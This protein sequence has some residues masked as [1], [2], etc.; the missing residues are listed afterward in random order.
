MSNLVNKRLKRYHDHNKMGTSFAQLSQDAVNNLNAKYE[1]AIAE[2]LASES[3]LGDHYRSLERVKEEDESFPEDQ[4]SD[5]SSDLGELR[6]GD[7]VKEESKEFPQDKSDTSSIEASRSKITKKRK[8]SQS[9]EDASD[10]AGPI[11]MMNRSAGLLSE[12]SR[13]LNSTYS[14]KHLK[15]SSAKSKVQASVFPEDESDVISENSKES[16]DLKKESSSGSDIKNVNLDR[17]EQDLPAR[18]SQHSDYEDKS[19]YSRVNS[20][21]IGLQDPMTSENLEIRRGHPKNY[22]EKPDDFEPDGEKVI[23]ESEISKVKSSDSSAQD[24]NKQQE[25]EKY[26]NMEYQDN[27][28]S[29]NLHDYNQDEEIIGQSDNQN[30]EVKGQGSY[31]DGQSDD[32]Q[33]PFDIKSA[34]RASNQEI[35]NAKEKADQN[36]IQE[37]MNNMDLEDR[38]G[39]LEAGFWAGDPDS[40]LKYDQEDDLYDQDDVPAIKRDEFDEKLISSYENTMKTYYSNFDYYKANLNR[41]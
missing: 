14:R 8:P 18:P 26:Q 25:D 19:E 32:E 40:W 15:Q 7:A 23:Q 39:H 28:P 9:D 4:D 13:P 36:I 11:S 20:K 5:I 29:Q 10:D 17:Y 16:E 41:F 31:L 6:D 21:H 38:Y 37:G 27:D 34:K 2:G 30:E 12:K 24:S 1:K 3:A 35:V 22:E 33:D